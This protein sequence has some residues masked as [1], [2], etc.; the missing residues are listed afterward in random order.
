MKNNGG[1]ALRGAPC[2]PSEH[3]VVRS[4]AARGS[5]ASARRTTVSSRPPAKPGALMRGRQSN[6]RTAEGP[7]CLCPRAQREIARYQLQDA[8][9]R[10]L[11][12]D[13]SGLYVSCEALAPKGTDQVVTPVAAGPRDRTRGT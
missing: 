3:V 4:P 5:R 13:A 1:R 2:G 11:A 9:G 6:A 8:T 10:A 7:P 12:G